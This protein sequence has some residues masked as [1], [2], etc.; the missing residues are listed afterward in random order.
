MDLRD[1]NTKRKN[2]QGK[3]RKDGRLR[4]GTWNVWTLLQ[5]RKLENAKQEIERTQLDILGMN[6]VRWIGSGELKAGITD[7]IN[8]DKQKVDNKEWEC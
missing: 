8:Q 1:G 7:C 5:G 4:N 2:F 3:K 6:D